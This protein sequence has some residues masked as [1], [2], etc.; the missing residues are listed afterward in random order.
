MLIEQKQRIPEGPPAAFDP[1]DDLLAWIEHNFRLY[2]DM[3]RASVFGRNVYVVSAPDYAQ[4]VLR[5]NWSNYKKGQAIKRIAML[6]GNGLMVSEGEFWKNQRR[7]I[8]PAF[9]RDIVAGFY[10]AM[11]TAN[12]DIL[13]NGRRPLN[14]MVP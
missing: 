2:G 3:Y 6:L 12:F 13:E 14:K 9:H 4:H 10:D 8:Q 1:S 5:N 11:R 7:M